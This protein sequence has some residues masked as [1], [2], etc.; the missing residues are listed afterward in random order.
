MRIFLLLGCLVSALNVSGAEL[1]FNLADTSEGGS[2]AK[3]TPV[4]GGSGAPA[5]W[6]MFTTEIPSAFGTF[7]GGA[8]VMNHTRV[9]AQ[10]SA[11]MTDERFPMLVYEGDIYRDFK[12]STRFKIVSGITEQMAGLIFRFQNASNFYVARVS[13]LGRNVRFY[14]VVNGVRSNPIGPTLPVPAGEWHKLGV[15]CEGNQISIL[16]DDKPVMP[17]L[18][19]NTFTEGRVGFWTKSDSVSY[20][21]D[22]EITFTPRIPPAQQMVDNVLKKQPRLLGLRIYQLQSDK[23]TTQVIASKDKAEIGRAG[24]EAELGA[25]QTGQTFYGREHG[26]Q[27]VTMPLRDRNGE[28]IA[29]LRVKLKANMFDSQDS[30][31]T[32]AMTVRKLLEQFST[33]GEELLK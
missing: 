13:A 18:G 32:R 7:A 23:T 27:I 26:A 31:I 17:K 21:T 12:F 14:K 6:K 20:F 22:A 11:D 16:L 33:N 2:P 29:A 28:N 10:T 24:T 15:Q 8:P 1:R 3:F 4:L 9:L 25:I 30:A 19:D 5:V